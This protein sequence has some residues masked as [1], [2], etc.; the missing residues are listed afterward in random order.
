M[1]RKNEITLGLVQM[2]MTADKG[3][4]LD[5]AVKIIGD[6]ARKGAEIICLPEL[7]NSIYF[8]QEENFDAKSI[9]EPIPGATTKALSEAARESRIILIGGSICEIAGNKLF[10][11]TVVFDQKGKIIGKYRKIHVPHDPNFYEQNYFRKGDLGYQV[12]DAHVAK[13]G[14]MICYDQWYP[15]AAR[16]NSI[17]GADIIFYPTAIGTVDGIEQKEGNWQEAWENVQRGHAIANGV[18]VSA[19]N[20]VGKE[21]RMNFWGGSFVIDQFGKTL[22]RSDNKERAIIAK[23][24]LGLGKKVKEGWRFFRNR[25]PETYKKILDK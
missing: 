18:I 7:F 1:N 17:M 20:R 12:I 6:A 23:C 13:I 21:G 5:K 11:T 9:A 4:N 25:R 10:N 15:E 14:T 24:D 22:V 2:G 8:P 3:K 16:I 19:V